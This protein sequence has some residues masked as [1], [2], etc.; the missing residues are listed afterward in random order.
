[1]VFKLQFAVGE[2][3][4]V[5]FDPKELNCRIYEVKHSKERVPAQSRH[6]MDQ[7]KCAMTTHRYGEIVGRYVIYRGENAVVDD[8]E[9]L[10]VEDYLKALR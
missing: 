3:D 4:M 8:V 9:Y 2:F 6:L 7:E 1:E 5:V 10:N